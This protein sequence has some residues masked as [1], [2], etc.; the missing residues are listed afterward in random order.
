AGALV[1]DRAELSERLL[2]AA[3]EAFPDGAAQATAEE[4]HGLVEVLTDIPGHHLQAAERC[5]VLAAVRAAVELGQP[6]GQGGPERPR[7]LAALDVPEQARL[8]RQ[9]P[10]LDGPPHRL[11]RPL[12][13]PSRA[14]PPPRP[15]P[16]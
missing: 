12:P 16:R 1:D 6:P 10:H 7:D 8:L 9:P 4:R 11:A 2:G 14:P 15:P 3:A 13:P 5:D